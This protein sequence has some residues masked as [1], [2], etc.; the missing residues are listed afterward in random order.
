[1][2][3][4]NS[5]LYSAAQSRDQ[6]ALHHPILKMCVSNATVERDNAGN[7]KLSKKRATVIDGAVP[8]AMARRGAVA[9]GNEVRR[10]GADRLTDLS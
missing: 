5:Q 3:V 10:G 6:A 7:R 9:D 8:L 2:S 1:M 4:P